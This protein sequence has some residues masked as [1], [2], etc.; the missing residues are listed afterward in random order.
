MSTDTAEKLLAEEEMAAWSSV[1]VL[2]VS[3]LQ[4]APCRVWS[5]TSVSPP[6]LATSSSSASPSPTSTGTTSTRSGLLSRL[7][8]S[9]RCP[10]SSTR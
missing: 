8:T 6:V 9:S 2:E 4:P 3:S 1:L 7:L 10:T 5:L